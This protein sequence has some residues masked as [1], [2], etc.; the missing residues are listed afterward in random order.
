[1]LIRAIILIIIEHLLARNY[2]MCFPC[3][4]S[5]IPQSHF[6]A[7]KQLTQAYA[8]C[9]WQSQKPIPRSV[10]PERSLLSPNRMP[11]LKDVGLEGEAGR[12]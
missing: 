5:F 1:M 7:F 2:P 11:V 10:I 9:L 3:M 12:A 6:R 8:A 4:I